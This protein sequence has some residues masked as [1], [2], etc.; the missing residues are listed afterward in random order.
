M[1]QPKTRRRARLGRLLV[2]SSCGVTE[3]PS[4]AVMFQMRAKWRR[5][6][7]QYSSGRL[8]LWSN[9]RTVSAAFRWDLSTPPIWDDES[10]PVVSVAYLCSA[11]SSRN[12]V[13]PASSPPPSVQTIFLLTLVVLLFRRNQ[14][15]SCSRGG[16]LFLVRMMKRYFVFLS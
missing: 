13:L 11:H 10:E 2:H 16:S 7:G 12:A 15:L 4:C 1:V 3:I 14:S 5:A 6:S 9:A 8:A